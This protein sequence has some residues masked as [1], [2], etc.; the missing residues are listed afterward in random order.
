MYY[1]AVSL[2]HIDH[3][4]EHHHLR[5]FAPGEY[6]SAMAMAGIHG[7]GR[8]EPTAGSRPLRRDE[9]PEDGPAL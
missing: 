1:L 5:R 2:E 6:E 4:V 8:G 7:R 9:T 3:F